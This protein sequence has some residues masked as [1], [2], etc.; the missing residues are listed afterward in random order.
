MIFDM[1][2]I[3]SC[4]LIGRSVYNYPVLSYRHERQ[5]IKVNRKVDRKRLV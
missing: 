5:R 3:V 1:K 2:T 4:K